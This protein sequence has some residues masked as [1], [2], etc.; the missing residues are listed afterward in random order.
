MQG[1]TKANLF[2]LSSSSIHVTYSST[3]IL[4][5][6]LLSYRDSQLS[7]SFRGKDIRIQDTEVGQLISVTLESIPDLKTVTFSLIL[8]MVT[9]MQ[10]SSGTRIKVVGLTTT[11]PTTIAGPPPGPQKLYSAVTL[12]GTAQFIV[13]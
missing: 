10:Q 1:F 2:E 6:P 12:R 11:E 13:P 8:P 3:S 5:G 7:L 9:V 4:G